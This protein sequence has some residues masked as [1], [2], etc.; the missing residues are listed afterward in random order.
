MLV[1]SHPPVE[2]VSF[3]EVGTYGG[4]PLSSSPLAAL[5]S[6]GSTPEDQL[7]GGGSGH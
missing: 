1:Y 3:L 5:V 7:E 6:P 4:N 2:R